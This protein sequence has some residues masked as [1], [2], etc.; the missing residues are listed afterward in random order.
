MSF[1]LQAGYH[2]LR[3][4]L[5]SIAQWANR[6]NKDT[7]LVGFEQIFLGSLFSNYICVRDVLFEYHGAVVPFC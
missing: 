5:S 6:I 7:A 2:G 1:V 3:K 4:T